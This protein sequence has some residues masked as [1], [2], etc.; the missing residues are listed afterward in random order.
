M[1]LSCDTVEDHKG[2]SKVCVKVFL[3]KV[4]F[5]RLTPDPDL[6][7]HTKSLGPS[8]KQNIV[9]AE[10]WLRKSDKNGKN[11]LVMIPLGIRIAALRLLNFNDNVYVG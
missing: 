3:E 1:A 9:D 7:I 2:W 11:K 10:Q 6:G 4:E 5:C 8:Q